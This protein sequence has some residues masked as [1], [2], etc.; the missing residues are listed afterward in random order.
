MLTAT[1]TLWDIK[2]LMYWL[3]NETSWNRTYTNNWRDTAKINDVIRRVSSWFFRSVLNTETVYKS[4]D[5][6]Y[7][8]KKQYIKYKE[9]IACTAAIVVGAVTIN[10][11]T[12]NLTTTWSIYSQWVVISYTWKN[13]TQ[14]TWCTGVV[15]DFEEWTKFEQVYKVNA[16]MD[17]PYQ[18][19]LMYDWQEIDVFEVKS[20]DDRYQRQAFKWFTL[21]YDETSGNRFLRVFWFSDSDKFLFKY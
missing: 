19:F 14:I 3:M 7:L 16:D 5:I 1:K 20:F 2:D 11:D 4:G 15:A 18:C 12:T 6:P 13:A 8:R 9:A 17:I 21:L 10:I